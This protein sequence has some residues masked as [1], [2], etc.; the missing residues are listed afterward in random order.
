VLPIKEIVARVIHANG[1]R[2]MKSLRGG[3]FKRKKK[4][5]K[6]KRKRNNETK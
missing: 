4:K 1:K 5:K 6:K 2:I 3:K